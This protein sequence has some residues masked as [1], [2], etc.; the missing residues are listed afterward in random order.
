M[1]HAVPEGSS[2]KV[3]TDVMTQRFAIRA[4]I[5]S[6]KEPILGRAFIYGVRFDTEDLEQRQRLKLLTNYWHETKKIKTRSKF[7]SLK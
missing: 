2:I 4:E 6:R 7:D 3:T 5:V 1:F